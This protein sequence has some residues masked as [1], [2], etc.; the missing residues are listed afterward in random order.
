MAAMEQGLT[1][2]PPLYDIYYPFGAYV[3]LYGEIAEASGGVLA[4]KFKQYK[5]YVEPIGAPIY[6]LPGCD[7]KFFQ[8]C[9]VC[10]ASCQAI[11]LS[12]FVQSG[13]PLS[14]A[15]NSFCSCSGWLMLLAELSKL[16]PVPSISKIIVSGSHAASLKLVSEGR[17]SMAAIDVVSFHLAQLYYPALTRH[18]KILGYT[19]RSLSLP[20]VTHKHHSDAVKEQIKSALRDSCSRQFGVEGSS[21]HTMRLQAVDTTV[22]FRDYANSIN[23]LLSMANGAYPSLMEKLVPGIQ[24]EGVSM[25]VDNTTVQ[26]ITGIEEVDYLRHESEFLGFLAHSLVIIVVRE[27]TLYHY[28][29]RITSTDVTI[30]SVSQAVDSVVKQE[31]WRQLPHGAGKIVLCSTR[32]VLLLLANVL[33]DNDNN[34]NVDV[35]REYLAQMKAVLTQFKQTLK[36]EVETA[37]NMFAAGF[38][39]RASDRLSDCFGYKDTSNL[40]ATLW[41]VDFSLSDRLI[42]DGESLGLVAYVSA[43]RLNNK[44]DWGNLVISHTEQGLVAWR[45][46]M[47]HS[48]ARRYVAPHCYEHIRLHRGVMTFKEQHTHWYST[49]PVNMKQTVFLRSIDES[50]L[51]Q[52]VFTPPSFYV[53]TDEHFEQ[54]L[55]EML[56]KQQDKFTEPL[57]AKNL[58][59]TLANKRT[60][61]REVI[62]YR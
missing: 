49:L 43:P 22:T 1:V 58:I 29:H 51:D 41:A 24:L 4:K 53:N 32:G 6:S 23:N 61:L 17:A 30:E 33:S 25:R 37:E 18:V 45:D 38:M 11:S 31:F 13:N 3:S 20:F 8:S 40:L 52:G 44:G 16:A 42:Q 59:S 34:N 36:G 35:D 57:N 55:I 10:H 28:R 60:F 14:V 12:E 2:L 7:G 54:E 27:I 39:G 26:C 48:A 46:S 19:E 62:S 50:T 9:I 15:V 47:S 56:Q 5:D 21:A